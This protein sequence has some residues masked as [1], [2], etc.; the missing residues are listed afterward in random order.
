VEETQLFLRAVRAGIA[1]PS[2]DRTGANL[3]VLGIAAACGTSPDDADL[4]VRD[5][6]IGELHFPFSPPAG[7]SIQNSVVSILR[8]VR[9]DIR[10]VKFADSVVVTLVI[11]Q[12]SLLPNSMPVP[13]ILVS[14]DKTITNRDDI[15]GILRA[16]D[17]RLSNGALIWSDGLVDL[18]GRVKRYRPFWL[19]ANIE[20]TD[21]QVRRIISHND[22]P[23]LFGALKDLALIT[24]ESRQAS[25]V[26]AD[27]VHFRQDIVLHESD[28]LWKALMVKS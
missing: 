16:D 18:F 21:P 9:A 20:N 11:D 23:D 6:E 5:I 24:V 4:P 28:A 12:W 25:V 7:I 27:F 13:Q 17:E 8:A 26:K 22:W 2:R 19:R 1:T 14:P 15:V 10:N 3:S